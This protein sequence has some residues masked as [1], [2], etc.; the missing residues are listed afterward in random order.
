MLKKE[1]VSGTLLEDFTGAEDF[2]KAETV[3]GLEDSRRLLP[4]ETLTVFTGRISFHYVTS[5]GDLGSGIR[6]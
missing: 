2:K 4:R 3:E 1:L 6:R 5:G